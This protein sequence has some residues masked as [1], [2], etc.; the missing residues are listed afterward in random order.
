[1]I[2]AT[3][4]WTAPNVI[5]SILA[6]GTLIMAGAAMLTVDEPPERDAAR[7]TA[8]LSMPGALLRLGRW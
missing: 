5:Q 1:M 7:A 4:D 3:G 6:A 2:L 8:V